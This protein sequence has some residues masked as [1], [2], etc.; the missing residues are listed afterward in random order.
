MTKERC[1]T[2]TRWR[3]GFRGTSYAWM[4]KW[5]DGST[6]KTGACRLLPAV[7]T[8]QTWEQSRMHEDDWCAEYQ[9]VIPDDMP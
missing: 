5:Q 1:E 4:Q 8:G 6:A 7:W 2:C 9:S 3:R